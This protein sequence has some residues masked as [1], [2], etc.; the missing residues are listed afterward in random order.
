M[1]RWSVTDPELCAIAK[2]SELVHI[3]GH[4][5]TTPL[6]LE[7]AD[8]LLR[9]TPWHTKSTYD[10]AQWWYAF[11]ACS[12]LHL[13][14][15]WRVMGPVLLVRAPV[16]LVGVAWAN[17]WR[18]RKLFPHLV[19]AHLLP[20]ALCDDDASSL[21]PIFSHW[22]HHL[23]PP[24]P[25]SKRGLKLYICHFDA[26]QCHPETCTSRHPELLNPVQQGAPPELLHRCM[27][28]AQC[29]DDSHSANAVAHVLSVFRTQ[30][31]YL[32]DAYV[33]HLL[34][35]LPVCDLCRLVAQ[36]VL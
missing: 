34:P 13:A 29:Y 10:L 15:V 27:M 22:W 25:H 5:H 2:A 14:E 9:T 26:R 30:L 18:Y 20:L 3:S 21:Q 19:E 17:D 28:F 32:I 1:H 16:R 4:D 8:R 36:Y 33:A 24:V 12:E 7:E 11:Q 31:A 6:T 23:K 35:I